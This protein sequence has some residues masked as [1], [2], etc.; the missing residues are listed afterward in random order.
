MHASKLNQEATVQFSQS[1][2]K[3]LLDDFFSS[4]EKITGHQII[5]LSPVKQVNF[6]VL[7][8]LFD[9]WQGE[10]KSLKSPYFDYKNEEVNSSLKTLANTLS[11]H[12]QIGKGDFAPLLEKAI[13]SSL[14]LLY[15]PGEF[16]LK[17][18]KKLSHKDNIKEFKAAG[19][20]FKIHK[21]LFDEL[22]INMDKSISGE[23]PILESLIKNTVDNF[24]TDGSEQKEIEE[25]FNN[26]LELKVLESDLPNTTESEVETPTLVEEKLSPEPVAEDTSFFD[27]LEEMV[28][29]EPR[30]TI[31][32]KI[33]EPIIEEPTPALKFEPIV[34]VEDP[35]E[36]FTLTPQPSKKEV[37]VQSSE[38]K[39]LN[40]QFSEGDIQTLNDKYEDEDKPE[41]IATTHEQK[42]T[43]ELVSSINI[44]QRYM[45]VNDLFEGNESDFELALEKIEGSDSFD[46]S[47]E[48][49][50]QNYS[51]KYTWDMNSDEV[52]EL[53]KLIFKRFR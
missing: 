15:S 10:I 46:S 37:E 41:T 19:K 23:M 50:V 27:N 17:E 12:I 30:K 44:N 2:A 39:S 38:I 51:R 7:K 47:V 14:Q 36:E 20:Y 34:K 21:D 9:Q 22:S 49:L 40:E 25:L 18:L 43:S 31:E 13:E 42:P 28:V 32:P 6:F 48:L 5:S 26:A 52:K 3:I 29:T 33:E 11:K 8:V 24:L 45:F 35:K 4:N 1:Y 16:Y 53:L